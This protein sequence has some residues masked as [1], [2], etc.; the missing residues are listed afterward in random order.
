MN[1]KKFLLYP[2]K[3]YNGIVCEL[4]MRK[5]FMEAWKFNDALEFPVVNNKLW[6][7]S[8]SGRCKLELP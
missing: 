6:G 2:R 8:T 1:K 4:V 3:M 5:R 7:L